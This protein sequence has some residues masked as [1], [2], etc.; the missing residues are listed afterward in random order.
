MKRFNINKIS[1]DELDELR[2]PTPETTDFDRVV[3]AAVSRRGFLTGLVAFGSG[4]AVM[5][6]GAVRASGELKQGAARFAF[7]PIAAQTDFTVH[8]P[9]GYEWKVLASWGDPLFS[10]APAFDPAN[11][12]TPEGRRG[13]SA[14]TPTAWSCSISTATR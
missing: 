4:A 8:V 7:T 14:R 9:E 12:T 5:G 6:A 3:Q 11:G 1:W 2:R 13:P 10:D